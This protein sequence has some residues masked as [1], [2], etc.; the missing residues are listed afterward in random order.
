MR[1]HLWSHTSVD[2]D[3]LEYTGTAKELLIGFLIALAILV[4]IYLVYFFIG[5]EAERLQA[6]A[7]IPLVLF[8][9]LFYQFAMY[10]ARR[11]RLSRTVWRGVRFW[12]TG[13][14][15]SYAWRAGLVDAAGRSS[16][17]DLRCPGTRPR[18]NA[19]RCGTASTAIS[20]D[21]STAPAGDAVQA[22][23]AGSGSW[24]L[25]RRS[26]VIG[27]L[28]ACLMR[29]QRPGLFEHC[30]VIGRWPSSPT[31]STRRSNGDGG[32]PASASA[33]CAS[34]PSL[35]T[36]ALFGLYWKVIGWSIADPRRCWSRGSAASSVSGHGSIGRQRH[37][38]PEAIALAFQRTPCPG[39]AGGRLSRRGARLRRRSCGSILRRDVWAR[40]AASMVDPQSGGGRQRRGARRGGQCAGRGLCRQPRHRR[41]LEHRRWLR[42]RREQGPRMTMQDAGRSAVYFDGDLEPQASGD[43]ASWRRPRHRRGRRPSSRPGRLTR[44]AASTDRRDCFGSAS[45]VGAAAGAPRDRRRGDDRRRVVARCPSLDV[46]R[47]GAGQTGAH[48]VLVDCRRSARSSPWSIYG[49]PYVAERLAPLVPY[50]V[51][52]RMG[53][54]VAGQVRAIFGGKVCERAR[55]AGGLRVAGR[56][57]QGGGRHRASARC[58]GP[59]QRRSETPSRCRAA[60]SSCSTGCCR[61]RS[62]PDELAGILAHELGHVH[63]RHS[64]RIADPDRRHVVPDRAPAR[65]R[66]RRQRRHLRDAIAAGGVAFARGRA[67]GGRLRRHG[68]A[69]ARPL[70]A[71]DG[72]TPVPHHRRGRESSSAASPSSTAIR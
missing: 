8:F 54:A 62:N 28:A 13:S 5:L 7:S 41:I 65:R 32:C 3:A 1:R 57:A 20:P 68:H 72:R 51:E 43:A 35:P 29:R 56:E 39:R 64:M 25:L 52:Q 61:R 16:R 6:F 45:H 33:T 37:R 26:S 40:V 4:P 59:A 70:A 44:S 19:T 49:I 23:S 36:G 10:R 12:M 55:R 15:W 2:G 69:E 22:A 24:Q 27:A 66:H 58:A 63:H 48:R 67:G 9:Y 17:S 38:A 30:V 42:W 14:G 46:D 53:E 60:R 21:A 71:A 34:N 50:A 47:G 31:P 18:S 11:Y